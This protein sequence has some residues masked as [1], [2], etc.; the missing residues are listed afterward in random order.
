MPKH[1]ELNINRKYQKGAYI[2]ADSPDA[3]DERDT[4]EF[5]AYQLQVI[6]VLTAAKRPVNTR[7]IHEQL[8]HALA[9]WTLDVLEI[10]NFVTR[11]PAYP[12]D[13]YSYEPN[14]EVKPVTDISRDAGNALPFL[15]NKRKRMTEARKRFNKASVLVDG[16]VT[17]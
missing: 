2:L 16:S 4:V 3:P 9:K 14:I 17:V 6:A 7:Y 13:L 11:M 8:G 5:K 10:T 1:N 15:A 12:S